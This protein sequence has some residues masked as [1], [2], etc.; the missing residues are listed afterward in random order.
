MYVL[1]YP[2][3]KYLMTEVEGLCNIL[4]TWGFFGHKPHICLNSQ[5]TTNYSESPVQIPSRTDQPWN[6]SKKVS[7][8]VRPSL[9]LFKHWWYLIE[10]MIPPHTQW[11]QRGWQDA[12]PCS[13]TVNG[14]TQRENYPSH[15]ICFL[16]INVQLV[17]LLGT[18]HGNLF[19][20][21][22]RCTSTVFKFLGCLRLSP[23]MK[24][25]M[26]AMDSF[27]W[28]GIQCAHQG[29]EPKKDWGLWDRLRMAL[30]PYRYMKH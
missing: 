2:H 6:T 23:C 4:L 5:T 12:V 9:E 11:N 7:Y 19:Y 20:E 29:L 24:T 25:E 28:Q 21:T 30:F 3:K 22:W 1:K 27:W 10:A 13:T 26:S 8:C 16:K 14:V 15:H 17:L 18:L